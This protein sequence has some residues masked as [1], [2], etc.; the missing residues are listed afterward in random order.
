M[1][2]GISAYICRKK[3]EENCKSNAVTTLSHY[4]SFLR[5][6]KLLF[7]TRLSSGVI[8]STW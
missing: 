4:F 1:S 7:Y 2:T 8:H 5:G 6:D 3:C